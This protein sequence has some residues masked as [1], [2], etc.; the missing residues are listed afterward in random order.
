MPMKRKVQNSVGKYFEFPF[1][2]GKKR[3]FALFS[4]QV[5]ANQCSCR[6]NTLYDCLPNLGKI[7]T[8]VDQLVIPT[9]AIEYVFVPLYF[10]AL[11]LFKINVR[12]SFGFFIIFRPHSHSHKI[13]L[14]KQACDLVIPQHLYMENVHMR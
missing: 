8:K 4:V 1:S 5:T 13:S 11:G 7:S 6:N 10:A 2:S 9:A 12:E 14:T 3:S